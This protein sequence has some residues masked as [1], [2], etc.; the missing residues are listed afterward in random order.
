MLAKER[1]G[2]LRSE[3]LAEIVDIKQHC[4]CSLLITHQC[5][6]TIFLC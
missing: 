6:V 2:H 1:L 4:L 3:S 5:A